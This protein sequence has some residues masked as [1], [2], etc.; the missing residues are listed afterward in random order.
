M[1][2]PMDSLNILLSMGFKEPDAREAVETHSTLEAAL[3]HLMFS[4]HRARAEADAA[5]AVMAETA[6]ALMKVG[7]R[8]GEHLQSWWGGTGKLNGELRYFF[9]KGCAVEYHSRSSDTWIHARVQSVDL[10]TNTYCLEVHPHAPVERVR[11]RRELLDKPGLV[12]ELLEQG[13][14]EEQ[15]SMA[16]HQCS[17]LEAAMNWLNGSR[18]ETENDAVAI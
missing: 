3:E 12:P 10:A 4:A 2:P 1:L 13:F 7:E 18:S 9:P 5:F 6:S 17:S 14:T 16:A 15:A 11:L 8:V